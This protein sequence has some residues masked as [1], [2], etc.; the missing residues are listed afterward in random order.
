MTY[1][2]WD[3][4]TVPDGSDYLI[5]VEAYDDYGNFAEDTSG[6]PFTIDNAGVSEPDKS[7]DGEE[8]SATASGLTMILT[9][10]SLIGILSFR[11]ARKAK[12]S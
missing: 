4:M 10:V 8:P 11:K 3:T 1:F 12:N 2:E 9:M 7:E 5:K 6:S